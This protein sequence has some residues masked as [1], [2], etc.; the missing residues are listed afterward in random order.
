MFF[1]ILPDIEFS[2]QRIKYR[3]TEQD[4]VVAKNIFREFSIRNELYATDLFAE[5]QIV[6]GA[7]PDF[8]SEAVYN[9]ADYDWVLLLT[10]KIINIY[11]DWPLS[12]SEFENYIFNKYENPQEI[13]HWITKEIK[14]DLGEIVQPAGMIVYY[15]PSDPSSYTLKHI[16]YYS[17]NSNGTITQVSE[18]VSGTQALESVTHYEYEQEENEKKRT[19]QIL[20]PTYLND[21][22][23]LFRSAVQ[24]LPHDDLVTNTRKRTLHIPDF[25]CVATNIFHTSAIVD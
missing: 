1:S 4:Y 12:N 7:R 6:D 11:K 8:V 15:D 25:F 2:Q 14:N 20:K 10:N 16:K 13:K 24:Y 3:F 18:T 9:N 5:F 22:V 17:T 19:I 23:G 21:F